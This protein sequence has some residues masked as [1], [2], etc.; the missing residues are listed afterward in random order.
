MIYRFKSCNI[1]T[2]GRCRRCG[3]ISLINR[4]LVCHECYIFIKNQKTI[5]S[6]RYIIK[7]NN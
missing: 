6:N 3:L 5:T 1:F 7:E 2:H 4:G